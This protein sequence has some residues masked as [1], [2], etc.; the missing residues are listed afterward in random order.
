MLAIFDTETGEIIREIQDDELFRIYQRPD[1]Q[2][3]NI[4]KK[5]F[6]KLY[7]D[8]LSLLSDETIHYSYF[9]TFF[10]L[11]RFM[12]FDN[13][14][15]THN[16]LP[17]NLVGISALCNIKLS[18]LK[19]HLRKL[20]QLEILKRIRTGKNTHILINPYFI[21]YGKNNTDIALNIFSKSKWAVALKYRKKVK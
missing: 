6:L 9:R 1:L 14:L 15:L 7:H 11:I 5:Y 3:Y 16:G 21:G 20:E 2:R 13:E 4:S 19:T 12:N 8:T 10:K 17:I 18:T